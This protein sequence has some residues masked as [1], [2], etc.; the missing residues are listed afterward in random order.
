MTATA[1][2]AAA[3]DDDPTQCAGPHD[4][5]TVLD[6]NGAAVPGCEHHGARALASLD[7]GQVEAGSVV[8]AATRVAAAAD[9]TPPFAWYTNA[10][11]TNA[12]QRSHAENRK[13]QP[14]A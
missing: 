6:R 10:P 7:G 1:R 14:P 13:A 12:D 5:V 2:C 11:R 4:A 3:H 8:G 9:V